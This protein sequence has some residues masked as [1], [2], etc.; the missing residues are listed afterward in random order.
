MKTVTIV[1]E[2]GFVQLVHWLPKWYKYKVID[3]DAGYR[4]PE[5]IPYTDAYYTAYNRTGYHKMRKKRR[6]SLKEDNG[7]NHKAI[8]PEPIKIEKQI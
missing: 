6:L 4:V 2:N 8:T 3:V 1:V 5:D 7:F